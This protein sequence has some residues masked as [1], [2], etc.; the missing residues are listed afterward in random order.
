MPT[1]TT[2]QIRTAWWP[3]VAA[4]AYQGNK[5]DFILALVPLKRLPIRTSSKLQGSTLFVVIWNIFAL[6][7]DVLATFTRS[8]PGFLGATRL[9]LGTL[10]VR[11]WHTMLTSQCRETG[12][13]VS[14]H[15]KF[16]HQRPITTPSVS[17]Q[18][19]N[20]SPQKEW[21]MVTT[22]NLLHDHQKKLA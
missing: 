14:A 9:L 3:A 20:L 11:N 5:C 2:A 7:V 10:R 16:L 18:N 6:F 19:Q 17:T 4:T 21:N 8:L 1:C 15:K 22:F 13:R 12:G